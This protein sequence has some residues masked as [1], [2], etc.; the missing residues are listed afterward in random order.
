MPAL[1]DSDEVAERPPDSRLVDTTSFTI[2]SDISPLL[3]KIPVS[4]P[5]PAVDF[6]GPSEEEHIG[7]LLVMNRTSI[8][9]RRRHGHQDPLARGFCLVW[10]L[11]PLTLLVRT[12]CCSNSSDAC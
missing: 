8:Y 12:A 5:A 11:S 9:A 4:K 7:K 3:P 6:G 10:A 2:N 1:E